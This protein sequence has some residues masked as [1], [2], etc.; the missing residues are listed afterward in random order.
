MVTAEGGG[1]KYLEIDKAPWTDSSDESCVNVT[2]AARLSE[3][4]AFNWT[5]ND[6]LKPMYRN[7]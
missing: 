7:D 2:S 1:E 5:N 6:H 3:I 4:N